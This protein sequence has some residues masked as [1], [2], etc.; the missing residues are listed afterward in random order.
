MS[1]TIADAEDSWLH[2]QATLEEWKRESALKF[3]EPMIASMA[4]IALKDLTPEQ[5]KE[6]LK[7]HGDNLHPALK[8]ILSTGY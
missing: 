5:R 6:L 2:G 8:D 7:Q 1:L 4:G 3:Y